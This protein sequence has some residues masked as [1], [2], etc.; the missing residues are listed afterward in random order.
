MPSASIIS[1][2]DRRPAM[3]GF[4]FQA[5][6]PARP[7]AA[8]I[9]ND[10][11]ALRVAQDLAFD[12]AAGAA[13]RDRDR[14]LP[15]EEIDRTSASGLW[16]ITVP[17]A[18]GGADVSAATLAS[19]TSILSAAD[20]SIG[21][22]P[23]NHFYMVEALRLDGTEAQQRFFFDLVLR[24]ARFGN[25]FSEKH[26]KRATEFTTRLRRDGDSYVLD[27]EKFYS[28][29][30]LFA[31]WIAAVASDDDGRAA[32][33]FL[34]ADAPGVTRRDDWSGFGQRTTASGT[35]VFERVAVPAGNVVPHQRAFDRPTAMGPLAQI[36]HAAVDT[37]IARAAIAE[38][39]FFV[40]TKSRPWIDSGQ[41][42]ASDDPYTIAAVGRLRTDLHAAEAMLARAGRLV[43][44]A[45]AAPDDLSV[46]EASV[47]V[48][49]AKILTTEIAMLAANK[50]FELSGTRATLAEHNL[51]RHWRN[52]RTHTLHDPVRWKYHAVGNFFLNGVNPPRYGAI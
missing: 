43:D 21:Q 5:V 14:R 34:P 6:P 18:Y 31:D 25:A 11:A 47:A 27:G 10:E 49:E 33:A 8:R 20:P 32:I 36:I 26:S 44:R 19:V 22:I 13:A 9:S 35:T 15:R 38:A 48:A 39:E 29:G 2:A 16:A 41:E 1:T 4:E 23:Q 17:R 51:D 7:D 24:G 12:L 42:R 46:A 50:L 45:R 40:R 30:V 52:A 28:S 37:G 3:P